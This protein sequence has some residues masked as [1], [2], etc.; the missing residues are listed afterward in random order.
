MGPPA[1]DEDEDCRRP[2]NCFI[3]VQPER[4][5]ALKQDGIAGRD[6]CERS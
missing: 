4:A 2:D 1:P 6:V 3:A 5:L